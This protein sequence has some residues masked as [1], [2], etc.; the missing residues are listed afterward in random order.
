MPSVEESIDIPAPV[1]RVFPVIT[2]PRRSLEWSSSI[3]SVRDIS[4]DPVHEGSTWRQTA[5]VVGREVEM[6]CTITTWEP[7]NRGILAITGDQRGQV[8]TIC[9]PDGDGT[10]VT[11]VLDYEVPHG[12][13][14]GVFNLVAGNLLH[15]ELSQ[16]LGRMRDAMVRE[17]TG[18]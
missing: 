9:R 5:M 2:D 18:S 4:D 14:G 12:I 7:P 6:T 10:R 16:S 13:A 11:Q 17:M 8:T 3:A 1:D 15:R